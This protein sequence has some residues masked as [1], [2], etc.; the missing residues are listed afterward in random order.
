M[1]KFSKFLGSIKNTISKI[2]DPRASTDATSTFYK[3]V[4][5]YDVKNSA[6][7]DNNVVV[8]DRIPQ[9][10]RVLLRGS[11]KTQILTKIEEIVLRSKLGYIPEPL[12][13][14]CEI[15]HYHALN[16]IPVRITLVKA[17]MPD[18]D[19]KKSDILD[20]QEYEEWLRYKHNMD[21]TD[22]TIDIEDTYGMNVEGG[23]G[24]KHHE[25]WKVNPENNADSWKKH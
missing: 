23:R 16:D 10:D 12:K 8:E 21:A 7:I 6:P 2:G 4:D 17:V 3:K 1:N 18:I 14:A 5:A 24:K 15:V 19:I 9:L 13:D 22:T 11:K 25:N 20:E